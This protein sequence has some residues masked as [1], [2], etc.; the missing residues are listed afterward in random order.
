MIVG[1]VTPDHEAVIRL[2]LRGVHRP[3]LLVDA[4]IDTG[5]TDFLTLPPAMIGTLGWPFR[6]S[7]RATLADGNEVEVHIFRG[8]VLWDG[9]ERGLLV[10]AADSEP[11]VGMSLLY[12]SRVTLDVVDGGPVVI[13]SLP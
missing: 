1:Q 10:V 13:E 8:V 2:R 4:A 11:L 5:F 7:G 12:G 3:E 6:E 9:R